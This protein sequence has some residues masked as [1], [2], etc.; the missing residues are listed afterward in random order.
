MKSFRI[1]I[2]LLA[3]SIFVIGALADNYRSA[4]SAPTYVH[5]AARKLSTKLSLADAA[6]QQAEIYNKIGNS[7]RDVQAAQDHYQLEDHQYLTKVEEVQPRVGAAAANLIDGSDNEE[8]Y[9]YAVT[10]GLNSLPGKN[11]VSEFSSK[12]ASW[13]AKNGSAETNT[14]Y[15]GT[16][17]FVNNNVYHGARNGPFPKM[18]HKRA[19]HVAIECPL[20]DISG[21]PVPQLFVWGGSSSP[22]VEILDYSVTDAEDWKFKQYTSAIQPEP[23]FGASAVCFTGR[24]LI[25]GGVTAAGEFQQEVLGYDLWTNTWEIYNFAG[26]EPSG[27]FGSSFAVNFHNVEDGFAYDFVVY[28]GVDAEGELLH[29]TWVLNIDPDDSSLSWTQIQAAVVNPPATAFHAVQVRKFVVDADGQPIDNEMNLLLGVGS[30][31]SFRFVLNLQTYVWSATPIKNNVAR[32]NFY[33]G[34]A[35]AC[36][37][38]ACLFFGGVREDAHEYAAGVWSYDTPVHSELQHQAWYRLP[39]YPGYSFDNKQFACVVPSEE[40][41]TDCYDYSNVQ[42]QYVNGLKVKTENGDVSGILKQCPAEWRNN[43]VETP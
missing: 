36:S 31:P 43:E 8:S 21:T 10:G 3:L 28:G 33:A 14:Y 12:V 38:N 26:V 34:F 37:P 5:H 24:V 40:E 9:W 39:C 7:Q 15:Y 13:V 25:F 11:W 41:C 42:Y 6:A 32:P 30:V 2:A 17:E 4:S 16:E 27:R 23:R 29:D 19:F 1:N 18:N 22:S 20:A 35:Y